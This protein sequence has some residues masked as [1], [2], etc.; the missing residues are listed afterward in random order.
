MA[1]MISYSISHNHEQSKLVV[2]PN[3]STTKLPHTERATC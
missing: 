2:S 1:V 3:Y